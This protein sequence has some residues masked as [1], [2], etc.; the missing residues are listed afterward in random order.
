[1][2]DPEG[3]TAT[4]QISAAALHDTSEHC[5]ALYYTV[6]HCTALRCTALHG[7]ILNC[8]ANNPK[9]L[10]T[11]H[12]IFSKTRFSKKFRGLTQIEILRNCHELCQIKR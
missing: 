7:S 11:V 2:R 5:T 10:S 12:L 4:R 6:L 8:N 9:L 3:S 1:M